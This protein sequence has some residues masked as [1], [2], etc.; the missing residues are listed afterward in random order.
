MP[1]TGKKVGYFKQKFKYSDFKA[2]NFKFNFL[3]NTQKRCARFWLYCG[4]T[5]KFIIKS[6]RN[7]GGAREMCFKNSSIFI[8][9]C[10]IFI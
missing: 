10:L 9:F 1:K 4:F 2:K 6:L 5:S 7:H 8:I 3:L